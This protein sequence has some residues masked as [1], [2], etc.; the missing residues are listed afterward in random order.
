M[1]KIIKI[2][3]FCNLL[4]SLLNKGYSNLNFLLEKI[5]RINFDNYSVKNGISYNQVYCI[6]QDNEGWIWFGSSM[7]IDRFDG[8]QFRRYILSDEKFSFGRLITRV[9]FETSNNE[10]LAGFED[11]G[12]GIYNKIE[13]KFETF[14]KELYGI[15]V[16]DIKEDKNKNIWLATNNGIYKLNFKQKKILLNFKTNL[17][18]T[19]TR[20]IVIDNKGKIWIGTRNGLDIFD[21]IDNK[22]QN[23]SK[24]YNFLKDDILELF[25]DSNNYLWVGTSKNYLIKINT[26]TLTLEN[27]SFDKKNERNVTI[28][29]VIQDGKYFWIGTRGGLYL[30]DSN[31]Q[32][33]KFYNNIESDDK[34][35]I[36]NSIHDLYVDFDKNLWIATRG[37]VS[38]LNKRKLLFNYYK[39]INNDNRYLNNGEIY[40]FWWDEEK[41]MLWIGTESGGI[42]ILDRKNGYFK[43]LTKENSKLSS[44]CIK[45]ILPDGCGNILIGTFGGGLNVYNEKTKQITIFKK[46]NSEISG[47]NIFDIEKDIKGMIW[48][49]TENGLN[50]FN[51]IK[52]TFQRINDFDNIPTIWIFNDSLDFWIGTYGEILIYNPQIGI[53]KSFK[54]RT[55]IVYRDKKNRYWVATED[56]GIALYDKNKGPISYYDIGNGLP[57]NMTFCI[58]EDNIGNLW[59]STANGLSCFNTIEIKFKNY[60]EEDGLQSNQ[61]T[62]GAA[63]K[64]KSGEL[65]FGGIK[66]FNIFNPAE[67]DTSVGFFTI[68]LSD[69]KIYNK[70]IK[71]YK[72]LKLNNSISNLK[73]IKIPSKYNVLTFCFTCINFSNDKKVKYIY[74]LEGFDKEWVT[75]EL[76]NV[77]YTN[78]KPGNYILKVKSNYKNT[79]GINL[80]LK[81]LPAF[82]QTLIFKISVLTLVFMLIYFVVKLI[83]KRK[84]IE[85]ALI[86]E[87]EKTRQLHELDMLKLQFYTS[88]SHELKTPLTLIIGPIEKILKS[89]LI[90][91]SLRKNLEIAY[92]NASNLKKS[93]EQLLEFRKI[94]LG[95]LKLDLKKGNFISFVNDIVFRFRPFIE[96]KKIFF[97]IKYSREKIIS[98]FDHQ[99]IEII[100]SNLLSNSIKFTDK[101]G[102]IS[103]S[104]S[105]SSEN[106]N[107]D[108]EETKKQIKIILKDTGKGISEIDLKN[109]FIPFYKSTREG[110]GIGLSLTKELIKLHNGKIYVES[111][112]GKGTTVTVLI[113]FIEVNEKE[114]NRDIRI[115][116]LPLVESNKKVILLIEDNED[117]R[118]FI[119]DYLNNNYKVI[120]AEDGKK[121][122]ELAIK[123]VPDIIITDIMLPEIGGIQLCEKLKKDIRTSHIPIIL[124]TVL[125]SKQDIINGLLKGADEYITKPF[126][127][128]ILITKIEN[129][130]QVRKALQEKYS[131][132]FLLKP[133]NITIKSSEE[134]FLQ[135]AIKIIEENIDNSEL[136][137]EKFSSLLGMSQIQL[138]RK[139]SALTNMTVKEFIND[140]RLKRAAELLKNS[141]LSVSEIAYSVGFT[142][143]SYFTKCFK[144]KFGINPTQYKKNK[145]EK[146]Q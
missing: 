47:N 27:I 76:P 124:L 88:I 86:L 112:Q 72:N 107:N 30:L 68:K 138:Y 22:I 58:L 49:C 77:T 100:I 56:K 78:L 81:I 127:I 3:V 96:E 132:E 25:L 32:I 48:I 61:F 12:L 8:N 94:E 42:N 136:D 55:R 140:I 135:K 26:N 4:F 122:Y 52:R 115:E 87:K 99:K 38:Y 62:Y 110:S 144:R 111:I 121:G 101:G 89:N 50:L 35:L 18:D 57:S 59:I 16:K 51:P 139:L 108:V 123:I 71:H 39:P 17:S 44:N 105:I 116:S 126:D 46:E 33:V 53:I 41:K 134:Q 34:S 54:E 66:G 70:S 45:A 102:K 20:K 106:N 11:F 13:D 93:I 146:I 21:P 64:L 131:K 129:L 145:E 137:V 84:N 37:G 63:I 85:Y 80:R 119:V 65:I 19:Y 10:L 74:Q 97:E 83:L 24:N 67:I 29:A 95:R 109:I 23:L 43:Y 120:E 28:R 142:D 104:I 98:Y 14:T 75:T 5:E 1:N 125:S 90:P 141:D 31:N 130:L 143:L 6:L 36:H 118:K 79:S 103:M 69:I 15:S 2:I 7:G 91:D 117:M 73:I 9:L 60:F 92:K 114:D 40:C 113:P 133:S 128:D 82:Y